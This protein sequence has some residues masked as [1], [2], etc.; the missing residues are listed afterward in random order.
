M[1][2]EFITE[3]YQK[4]SESIFKLNKEVNHTVKFLGL[5]VAGY[6]SGSET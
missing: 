2:C 5:I 4:P 3:Q 6:V 1:L